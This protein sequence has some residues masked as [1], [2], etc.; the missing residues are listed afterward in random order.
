VKQ[1]MKV[2]I[3][4]FRINKLLILASILMSVLA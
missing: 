1:K 2:Q 4:L 3:A